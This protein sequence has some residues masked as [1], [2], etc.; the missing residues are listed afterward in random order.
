MYSRE[1]IQ[2]DPVH[3][4]PKFPNG[5]ILHNCHTTSQQDLTLT[6]SVGL[7]HIHQF[8]CTWVCGVTSVQF[9]HM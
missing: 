2:R 7:A 5:N 3:H 1:I 4:L 6:Q 8:T 9:Y